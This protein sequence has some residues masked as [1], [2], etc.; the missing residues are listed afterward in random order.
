MIDFFKFIIENERSI[1][2]IPNSIIKSTRTASFYYQT[3][4]DHVENQ[5]LLSILC[6]YYRKA[7]RP[8]RPSYH[9]IS[10]LMTYPSIYHHPRQILQMI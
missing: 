9:F 3:F 2:E 7:H 10:T 5:S 6:F 4:N 8:S 1:I